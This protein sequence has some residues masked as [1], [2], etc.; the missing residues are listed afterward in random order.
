MG[1]YPQEMFGQVPTR[2]Y[3]GYVG[4]GIVGGLPCVIEHTIQR[5]LAARIVLGEA[6]RKKITWLLF[7]LS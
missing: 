4:K 2:R 6:L 1:P 3:G 7:L 5:Q